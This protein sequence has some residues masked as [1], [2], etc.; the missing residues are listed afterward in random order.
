MEFYKQSG[1]NLSEKKPIIQLRHVWKSFQGAVV[2]KDVNLDIYAGEILV[3]MGLSGC[4]KSTLLKTMIGSL[5]P[6]QG[7]VFVLGKNIYQAGEDERDEIRKKCGM[8]FQSAAL[9]DS[10]NVFENVGLGLRD[11][12]RYEFD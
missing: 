5:S 1:D 7:T 2:L 3:I 12:M 8:L 10:M 11:H 4:G 9:F 6:D